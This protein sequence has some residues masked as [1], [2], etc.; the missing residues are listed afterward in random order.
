MEFNSRMKQ[1]LTIE[2]IKKISLEILINV[3]NFCDTH[4]IEYYL[5][6]GTLLGAIRHKGFIPWDDDVDIMMPRPDYNRFLN[7]YND[8]NYR[9]IKPSEGRYYYAKVADNNTIKVETRLDNKKYDYTGI[10]IDIFP[11]DGIIN[12]KKEIE[13]IRKKSKILETLLRLSNQPIFYRKNPIKCINRIIPR[14]LGSKNIVKLIERNAQ[15]YSYENSDYVIRV[16]NT[17][18]GFT[19]AMKKEIYYPPKKKEF[20]GH[21]F[22]VPNDYDKW[23]TTFYGN[24]MELPPLD[25]R[26][27]HHNSKCYY[28]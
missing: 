24:Y 22:N 7:E 16:R 14:M 2:E 11:L 10:D 21:L 18:N 9:L 28:R 4:N 6:C 13:N 27:A 1:E 12:D 17:P 3:S 15:T 26:K 8:S 19:G 20:E 25:K 5:S 23:L